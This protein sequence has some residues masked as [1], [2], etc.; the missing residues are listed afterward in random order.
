[1]LATAGLLGAAVLMGT[2]I[3]PHRETESSALSSLPATTAPAKAKDKGAAKKAKAKAK[4]RKRKL[5]AKQLA[6]RASAVTLLRTQGYLPTRESDYDPRHQLRVLVG[7]RNG[8]PLGPR[9][10]FLFAG[11]RF[12]GHDATAGSSKLAVGKSGNRWVTLA[13]GVYAPGGKVCCPTSTTK[14]RFTWNGSALTPQG[15]IPLSRVATG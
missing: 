2:W 15:A 13:Y 3:A 7:Y 4:A 14:V 10:A 5:T 6:A 8:D 11:N 9:R 1:M 12:I